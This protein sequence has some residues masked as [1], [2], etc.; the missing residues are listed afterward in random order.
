MLQLPPGEGVLPNHSLLDA[1]R[2]GVIAADDEIP[3]RNVQPASLDLRLGDRA[4]RIRCSFLPDDE[5]VERKAKA[6]IEDTLDLTR[7]GALLEPDRPY[8]IPLKERLALPPG[9]SAKANPKSSTGRIDVFTRVITDRSY[10][11]DE[12]ADGYEG[13]LYL[14]VVPLSFPVRVGMDLTLNQVRLSFGRAAI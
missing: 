5:T 8:L 3:E 1:I 10:R 2:A 7:D 6:F 13:R 9:M 12:I 11:F 14:E 4:Y